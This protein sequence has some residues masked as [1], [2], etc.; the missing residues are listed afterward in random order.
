MEKVDLA[1]CLAVDAS[2][3][4]D[5]DEFAL[6]LGGYA[7]AFRD[8]SVVAALTGGPRGASAAAMLLWSG[9]GA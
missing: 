6:M 1:L 7:A 9:R 2:S 5:Y 4:V 3:S 8:D